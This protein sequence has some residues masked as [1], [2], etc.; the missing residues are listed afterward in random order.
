MLLSDRS[1]S[2]QRIAKGEPHEISAQSAL[3]HMMSP[4]WIP[5]DATGAHRRG[6]YVILSGAEINE[7]T[8]LLRRCR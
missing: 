6:A 7:L 1:E 3:S 2:S 4:L 8:P 5:K